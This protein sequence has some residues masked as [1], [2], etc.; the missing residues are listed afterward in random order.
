M[1]SAVRMATEKQDSHQIVFLC[2]GEEGDDRRIG[3]LLIKYC[4]YVREQERMARFYQAADLY[5]HAAKAEVLPK[6][7]VEALA[8]ATPVVATAVAGIPE[9]IKGLGRGIDFLTD[10]NGHRP[11]EA[12]GI[13]TPPGDAK[14]MARGIE[15]LLEDD[16]LSRR[17]SANAADDARQRFSI[18]RQVDSFLDWY[19]EVIED[20]KEFEETV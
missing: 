18:E 13:L 9:Q 6:T 19:Q 17:L 11:N 1:E 7:V 3:N 10:L 8:C 4:G 20:W 16:C 12:T 15:V 2:V 5:I 14:A